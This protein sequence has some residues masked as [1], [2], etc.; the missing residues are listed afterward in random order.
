MSNLHPVTRLFMAAVLT[1]F[2]LML[3]Q[4]TDEVFQCAGFIISLIGFGW[5]IGEFRKIVKI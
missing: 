5:I 3:Q 4:D 1:A 2:G